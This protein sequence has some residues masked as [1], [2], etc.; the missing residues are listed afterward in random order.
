MI[1]NGTTT[2]FG[3]LHVKI[4]LV[5]ALENESQ[6]ITFKYCISIN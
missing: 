1:L 2:M 6:K 3:I 5:M 4:D